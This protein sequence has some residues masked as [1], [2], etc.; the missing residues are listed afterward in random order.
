MV[1]KRAELIFQFLQAA[2]NLVK[3]KNVTKDKIIAFA[4]R[5]FG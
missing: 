4:K 2:R 5:Q 3:N 1:K